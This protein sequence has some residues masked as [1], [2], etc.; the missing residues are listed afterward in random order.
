MRKLFTGMILSTL[1]LAGGQ[2]QAAPIMLEDLGLLTS[3]TDLE[4]G[5]GEL[6]DNIWVNSDVERADR[7]GIWVRFAD[8]T[9]GSA[10]YS[11]VADLWN[12]AF[13]DLAADTKT[14]FF[15]VAGGDRLHFLFN[16]VDGGNLPM[17]WNGLEMPFSNNFDIDYFTYQSNSHFR[18]SVAGWQS[19]EFAVYSTSGNI[20]QVS[21]PGAAMLLLLALTGLAY[22]RKRS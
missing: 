14:G 20:S 16:S 9:E 7:I 8:G 13:L 3:W 4:T 12:T 17:A 1:I 22:R 2:V 10:T 6:P 19:A 11:G 21:E 5:N 18:A 15:D